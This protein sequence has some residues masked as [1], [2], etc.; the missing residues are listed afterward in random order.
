[1]VGMIRSDLVVP[2]ATAAVGK[3]ASIFEPGEVFPYNSHIA[4]ASRSHAL[5]NFLCKPSEM[6]NAT[7]LQDEGGRV[8]GLN[9]YSGPRLISFSCGQGVAYWLS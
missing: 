5:W 7:E 4:M 8:M 1:M 2:G 9:R 3:S 6:E